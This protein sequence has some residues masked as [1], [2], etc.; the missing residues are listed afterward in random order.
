MYEV[1]NGSGGT[2]KNVYKVLWRLAWYICLSPN[3]ANSSGD[4]VNE[5]K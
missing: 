1:F 5:E 3:A 4:D 2:N